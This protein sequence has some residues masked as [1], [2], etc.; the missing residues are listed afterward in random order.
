MKRIM[1][2]AVLLTGLLLGAC[3]GNAPTALPTMVLNAPSSP[4]STSSSGGASASAEAVPVNKV[5]LS[6]PLTGTVKTINVKV[7]DEV[8]AGDPLMVLDT[9][10]LEA[11]VAEA[12]ADVAA[13]ETQVRY[14]RRVGPGDEQLKAALA[15]VDRANA[16][17]AQMQAMLA[18]A[19]LT[20]PIAGTV[21][22]ID[23]APGE[24]AVPGQVVI[25]I[26]DLTDMRIETTDLS[27]R[28]VAA[29][30]IGQPASVFIEAL[31][32][33][34]AGKVVDIARTSE[35]V[36]GDVVYRVTIALDEQP[37]GLRW[38]MSADVS[39]PTEQ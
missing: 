11:R 16:S 37:E 30:Q 9:V 4:G 33:E 29:I 22:S 8:K 6:F 38:G 35:E 39:F 25:R 17:L 34:F 5:N 13:A 21:V 10:I 27:E 32:A 28:D 36:G 14:L 26:G 31:G 19:T 15:D 18:Q 3:T 20:S 23:T 24:T 1:L 12:Q 2:I 7:G